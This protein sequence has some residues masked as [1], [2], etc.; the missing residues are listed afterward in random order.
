MVPCYHGGGGGAGG[1][2][3]VLK[4]NLQ[5]SQLEGLRD[6]SITDLSEATRI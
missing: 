2:S 5:W 1:R 4:N 3:T 6:L